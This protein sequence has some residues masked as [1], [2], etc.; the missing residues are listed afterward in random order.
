[1]FEK[2]LVANRGEIALRVIR[3]CRDLGVRTV[4]VHSEADR[5]AAFVTMADE[6]LEIGPAPSTAASAP[7][8][9]SGV[10]GTPSLRTTSTSSGAPSASATPAATTTPPRGKPNTSGG[11]GG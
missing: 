11:S 7:I 8:A 3:G 5:H 4:A 2:V 10:P 6:A 9:N 1:M